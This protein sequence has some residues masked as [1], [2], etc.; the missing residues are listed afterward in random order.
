VIFDSDVLI[1]V[2]R[3]DREAGVL[4]DSD[5]S[6]FVSIVSVIEILQGAKSKA[7]MEAFQR[8]LRDSDFEVLG[9]SAAIGDLAAALIEDHALSSGIELGD[10]LIA[11]TA[12]ETGHVLATANV[13]HFRSVPRLELKPFRPRRS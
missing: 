5:P 2:S 9:L 13:R 4:V 7:D 8:S 12:L 1:A 3:G 6:P 10:A 11:A